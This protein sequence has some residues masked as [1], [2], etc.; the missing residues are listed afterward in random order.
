M[1][2][3]P[4]IRLQWSN[5]RIARV[6]SKVTKE[7][8]NG[9]RKPLKF[10]FQLLFIL[11]AL[12]CDTADIYTITGITLISPDNNQFNSKLVHKLNFLILQAMGV[13]WKRVLSPTNLRVLALEQKSRAGQ[14]SLAFRFTGRPTATAYS[15]N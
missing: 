1:H 3:E 7:H 6:P 5:C 11:F 10:Q 4:Q 8:S 13:V 2:R 14:S 15:S 9:M 12:L